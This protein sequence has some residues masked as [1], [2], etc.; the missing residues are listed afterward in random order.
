MRKVIIAIIMLIL[1]GVIGLE[2]ITFMK[3]LDYRQQMEY[4][5][6]DTN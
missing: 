5:D 2:L 4:I 3:I 1:I 6:I